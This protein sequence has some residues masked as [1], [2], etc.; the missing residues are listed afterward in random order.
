MVARS[1]RPLAASRRRASSRRGWAIRRLSVDAREK[2]LLVRVH[3]EVALYLL[4]EEPAFLRRLEKEAHLQLN[5]RD[6]PL[7]QQ[8]EFRLLAGSGHQDVTQRY[9]LG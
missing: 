4:E 3:P 7:M 1:P 5:L 8:D 6:D 2:Q 9:A